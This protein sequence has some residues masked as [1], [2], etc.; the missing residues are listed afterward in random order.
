MSGPRALACHDRTSS[1]D[2]AGTGEQQGAERFVEREQG[3]DDGDERRGADQDRGAGGP[4]VADGQDEED[5]GGTRHDGADGKERPE[6]GD[7]GP[8]HEFR[9]GEQRSDEKTEPG[10]DERSHLGIR[11]S[12]QAGPHGQREHAE[13]CPGQHPED[14][15]EHLVHRSGS[16]SCPG[17]LQSGAA[18]RPRSPRYDPI[19]ELPAS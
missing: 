13:K 11:A 5:L 16:H 12:G 15:C 19:S 3:D 17:R 7:T 6:V 14:D 2:Q 10:D 9:Q 18:L 4:G 1:D 8:T